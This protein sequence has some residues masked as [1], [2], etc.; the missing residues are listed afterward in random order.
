MDKIKYEKGIAKTVPTQ[1]NYFGI[2]LQVNELEV[3]EYKI[4]KREE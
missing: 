3:N 1:Y 2:T 4:R